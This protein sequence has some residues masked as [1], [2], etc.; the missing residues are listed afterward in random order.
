MSGTQVTCPECGVVLAVPP[1]CEGMKGKCRGC[2]AVLRVDE[3]L[4]NQPSLDDTIAGWLSEA[5]SSSE[6]AGGSRRVASA[7]PAAKRPPA[8]RKPSAKPAAGPSG[9]HP[10]FALRLDHVDA[11]GAFFQFDSRVL[12]DP[13]F[14]GSF[15]QKCVVCGGRD[16]LAVHLV[17]WSA[18]KSKGSGRTA[19]H[20]P[21]VFDLD[22]FKGASG[23][24]I[25]DM[26]GRTNL[27]SEPYCL[28]FPYY[29]CRC[30]SPVG[31]LVTDIRTAEDG[32]GAT[33][34]LGIASLQQAYEWCIVACGKDCKASKALR[35]ASMEDTERDWRLLPLAVRNRIR[36]WYEPSDGEKFV[37]YI[38]D[39]DFTQAEA[40]LA[41]VV[42][43]DRR[44]VYHKSLADTAIPLNESISVEPQHDNGRT[45]VRIEAGGHKPLTLCANE[46]SAARL[47]AL[48]R[49]YGRR[50]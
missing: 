21:C 36:Q 42:L 7:K 49:R 48:L 17:D 15:P 47:Q 46:S 4:A 24:E 19:D 35:K 25:V 20:S 37:A 13:E 31:A 18:N 34:E 50:R 5:Q 27:L 45:K 39:A 11:M 1:G 26:I 12:Y 32:R 9:A 41:G 30:C 10:R 29:V 14:R 2:G 33:C 28:P 6:S 8:K 23:R 22:R 38:Q 16:S 44:L 3:L 40:G 43:T